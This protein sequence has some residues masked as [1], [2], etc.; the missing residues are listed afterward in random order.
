MSD[1]NRVQRSGRLTK[2][3][4]TYEFADGN[5]RVSFNV[6]T[7][8]GWKDRDSG[9]WVNKTSFCQVAIFNQMLAKQAQSLKKGDGVYVEGALEINSWEKDGA[10]RTEPVIEVRPFGE[11]DLRKLASFPKKDAPQP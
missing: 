1:I 9:E 4:E 3:P 7:S 8:K 11:G 5:I 2:D 6:A 10:K